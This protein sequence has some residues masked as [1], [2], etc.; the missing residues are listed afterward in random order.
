MNR[1]RSAGF[2][3]APGQLYDDDSEPDSEVEACNLQLSQAQA[4]ACLRLNKPRSPALA[5]DCALGG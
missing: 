1:R 3:A 5:G 2:G 4:Q